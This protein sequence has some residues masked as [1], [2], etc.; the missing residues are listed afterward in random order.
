M[1]IY[2]SSS[3]SIFF[4]LLPLLKAFY[5]FQSDFA[6]RTTFNG[7]KF[8]SCTVCG[9]CVHRMVVCLSG[10]V[11]TPRATRGLPSCCTSSTMWCGTSAGPSPE[12]SLPSLAATTRSADTIKVKAR[13]ATLG[14]P[15]LW[16]KG[17]NTWQIVDKH[18]PVFV[19]SGYDP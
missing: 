4:F 7:T 11:M 8:A 3:T 14:Q 9:C 15:S 19:I 13:V 6:S 1:T 5:S 2:I 10:R 17:T 16:L 18:C 12:T